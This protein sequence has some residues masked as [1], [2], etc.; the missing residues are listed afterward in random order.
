MKDTLRNLWKEAWF[1]VLLGL[2]LIAIAA[3]VALVVLQPEGIPT[4]SEMMDNAMMGSFL[5]MVFTAFVLLLIAIVLLA[6]LGVLALIVFMF[7]LH[8]LVKAWKG[9]N[10]TVFMAMQMPDLSQRYRHD[11]LHDFYKRPMK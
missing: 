10:T 8:Q 2:T 3:S 1:K 7:G 4:V 9:Q 5:V 11:P 6:V